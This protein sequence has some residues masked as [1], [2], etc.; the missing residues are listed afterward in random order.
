MQYPSDTVS[1]S[2]FAQIPI[3]GVQAAKG[4]H[5]EELSRPCGRWECWGW[6]LGLD[7]LA[8]PGSPISSSCHP[9]GQ[10]PEDPIQQQPVAL[11]SAVRDRLSLIQQI[12]SPKAVSASW[13]RL[14]LLAFCLPCFSPHLLFEGLYLRSCFLL[15][16]ADLTPIWA[17]S[18]DCSP[19]VTDGVA[20]CG[21]AQ[22]RAELNAKHLTIS[23]HLLRIS[24]EAANSCVFKL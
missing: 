14:Q 13:R 12:T 2:D 23:R 22:S 20:Q 9:G 8:F 17:Q 6:Q 19:A 24:T 3:R 10:T 18:V 4:L 7:A 15:F 1:S 11:T 16:V 21:P 5:P